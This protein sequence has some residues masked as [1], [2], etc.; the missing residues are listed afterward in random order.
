MKSFGGGQIVEANC[1]ISIK[2]RA[3]CQGARDRQELGRHQ[4]RSRAFSAYQEEEARGVWPTGQLG[5]HAQLALR[6]RARQWRRQRR[7]G[8]VRRLPLPAATE[9][10]SPPPRSAAGTTPSPSISKHQEEAIKLAT[11]HGSKE[12]QKR[13]AIEQTNLPTI[14]T[15]Y[16]DA[17]VA[18]AAPIIPQWKD[19]FMNAVPRPSARRD[20]G[21]VQ[22]GRL[23]VLVGRA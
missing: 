14:I 4:S 12:M 11:Y 20:Q 2:Q 5:L 16:D 7:E 1:D 10:T 22:R 13:R 23:A 21:E 6:L 8:Q 3:R 9:A 19:V 17:D 15:L 18:K